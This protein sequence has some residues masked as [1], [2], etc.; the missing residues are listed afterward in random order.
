M[1]GCGQDVAFQVNCLEI[2]L[3]QAPVPASGFQSAQLT[4]AR[5][6]AMKP[7]GVSANSP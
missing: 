2:D 4:A 1:P 7:A 3:S 5:C 6:P